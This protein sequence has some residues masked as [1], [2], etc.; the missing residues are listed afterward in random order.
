[1]RSA[2]SMRAAL[3]V[4]A[5][6]SFLVI[7]CGDTSDRPPR[8]SLA[9]PSV[10]ASP[11]IPTPPPRPRVS[12][13]AR[14][15]PQSTPTHTPSPTPAALPTFTPSPT[16]T[17]SPTSTPVPPTPT[18]PPTSAPQPTPTV[19]LTPEPTLTPTPTPT[20]TP[21]WTPLPSPTPIPTIESNSQASPLANLRPFKPD[22]WSAPIVITSSRGGR[23]TTSL[24]QGE[25]SYLSWAIDNPSQ[26][27]VNELFYVDVLL[28]GIVL[29]R[30]ISDG[31][32][33]DRSGVF[34]DWERLETLARIEPGEHTLTL[35]VDSTDLV[36]ETDES[37]NTF[38]TKMVVLPALEAL[39]GIQTPTPTRLP[40][41]APFVP[42][43]WPA[44][45]IASAYSGAKL[46]GPLSVD[47]LSYIRYALVNQGL[48]S[49]PDN[50][51]TQLY[52]DGVLVSKEFWSGAIVDNQVIRR[53]WGG[54]SDI[55]RVTPGEHTLKFLVDPHNL[56]AESDETNNVYEVTLR[57]DSGEVPP[58][59][60]TPPTPIP[61][62]PEPPTLPNLVPGWRFGW[63]GALIAANQPDTFKN[64]QLVVGETVYID[65]VVVNESSVDLVGPYQVNLYFDDQLVETLVVS[66]GTP[67]GSIQWWPDWEGLT[68][69]VDLTEG[70]H[71]LRMEIDKENQ[72]AELD[73]SDNI[74]VREFEWFAERIPPDPPASYSENDLNSLLANLRKL[75]D[76]DER[77]IGSE[78]E[79]LSEQVM[80][81]A[82]AGY[83]LL[84]GRRIIDENVDIS[85]LSHQDFIDWLD[86]SCAQDYVVKDPSRY[87]A[88]RAECERAKSQFLGFTTVRKGEVVVV[89]DGER[90]PAGVINTLSHELGHMRQ[91]LVRPGQ[92][93]PGGSIS[94][95]GLREAEA[96]QFP[97]T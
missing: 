3:L 34:T 49:T 8:L 16:L 92:S 72:V 68:D 25:G 60:L 26:G 27:D 30:W 64:G 14:D 84:T 93:E 90:S 89:V 69:E 39:S 54:L 76:S 75:V 94:L 4:V 66:D 46:Q 53:E 7:S 55:V 32:R 57:W 52:F 81:V 44:P 10:T 79:S 47:V 67:A 15:I 37:D 96:Q 78:D 51:H 61:D 65:I 2:S 62:L 6:V 28:D 83:Y 12:V 13:T 71:V 80:G 41:L 17:P 95:S 82:D 36:S 85:L 18:A 20:P 43:G 45:I 50:V 56:I 48:A 24:T 97:R 86:E 77:V 33:S 88:I 19:A 73:E 22:D 31:L 9:R 87:Q 1:M 38:Q 70:V 63:D 59:Q 58:L 5:L 91:T 21:T 29:D 40:D 42:P 35:V 74:F 11:T 23:H